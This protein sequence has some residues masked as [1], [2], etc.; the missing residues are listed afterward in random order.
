MRKFS[1]YIFILVALMASVAAYARP[2]WKISDNNTLL[3]TPVQEELPHAD[4]ME[5]SGL[6]MSTVLFW[7]IDASGR[8]TLERSLIHPL[9][10]VWPNNTAAHWRYRNAVY[11]PELL[12]VDGMRLKN[13]KVKQVRIDGGVFQYTGEFALAKDYRASKVYPGTI[14]L[15]MTGF[16]STDKTAYIERYEL[17]NVT[18]SSVVVR[19]PQMSQTFTT[20]PEKGVEGSYTSRMH[21]VGDGEFTLAKGESVCF[22]LVFQSWKTAQHPEVIVPADE[23]AKRYAF[24]REKMDKSLVFE[25]PDAAV[26]QMFRY[27]KIRACESIFD[28][29]KGLMHAPGGTAFYAAVWCNDQSEFTASLFPLIGYDIANQAQENCFRL[30][31]SYMKPTYENIPSSIISEGAGTWNG[32]GDRGDVAMLIYGAARYALMYGS[33]DKAKEIWPVIEW[34]LEFCNRKINKDGVVASDTDELEDRFPSGDANLCT[35]SLYYDALISSAYLNDAMKG[36]RSLSAKY[37]TQAAELRANMEKF[38]GANV[39]GYDTYRYYEGNDILRS[40]ICIPLTVGIYDRAEQTIEALF[41]DKLWSSQGCLTAQGSKVYW[42]RTT[43]YGLRGAYQAGATQKATDYLKFYSQLRLLGD[44]IPYPIEAWPE[45]GQA[46]LAG[47]AALACRIVTE[48]LFGIRPTGFRTFEFTPRLPQEWPSMA[49]RAV[50]AFGRDFDVE[51]SRDSASTLLVTV[52]S[53]EGVIMKR[54]I[55]DGATISM[56]L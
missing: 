28:T 43:L 32:A 4:H 23:Q 38:F 22:D 15:K 1:L 24:I 27:S 33:L 14:E 55:K 49:L 6:K 8:M 30:F 16:T 42:D 13:E 21:I 52:S 34:G 50:K 29:K 37:R 48:G 41:S 36:P 35:S 18:R 11:V 54:K 17:R 39:Q 2:S 3:W 20:A 10:R 5:M 9:L 12:N 19:I 25:C 53:A 40:W 7:D 56:K 47:E 45:G 26:A 51:V 31:G 46:H 44:H